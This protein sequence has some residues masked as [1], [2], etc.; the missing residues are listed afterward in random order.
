MK[1]SSPASVGN[2]RPL[3]WRSVEGFPPDSTILQATIDRDP[4]TFLWS[5]TMAKLEE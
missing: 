1:Q 2:Y 5:S 4:L 3:A